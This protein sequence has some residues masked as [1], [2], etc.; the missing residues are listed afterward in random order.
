MLKLTA[1]IPAR[2]GSKRVPKK[3]AR[4][5]CGKPLLQYAIDVAKDAGCFEEIWVNTESEDLGELAASCGVDFHRRPPELAVDTATNQDFTAEFLRRLQ[6][7]FVVMVNPT[8]PL[9]RPETV[10]R[11]CEYLASDAY[12]TVLSVLEEKAECFYQGTPVNFRTVEKVNSQDLAPVQK[13]IWAMTAWRRASF[14]HTADKGECSVFAGR[15]GLFPVPLAES[16][17]IDTQEQWDLA[18]GMLLAKNKVRN[19]QENIAYWRPSHED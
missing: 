18:E 9:L 19:Q 16:L 6:C 11:F 12:D 3:N 8:S 4:L 15:L 14:L 5:L 1:M 13:V 7:D 17:D 10:R 2:M